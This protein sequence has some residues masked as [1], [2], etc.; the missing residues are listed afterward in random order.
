MTSRWEK[1]KITTMNAGRTAYLRSVFLLFLF[2]AVFFSCSKLENGEPPPRAVKG[3]LDLREWSFERD[4][5]VRLDGAWAFAWNR[6]LKPAD[7][8]AG[9]AFTSSRFVRVPGAWNGRGTCKKKS[10]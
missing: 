4:G 8:F 3:V 2:P 5:P 1:D 6:H 7:G 10:P 9:E